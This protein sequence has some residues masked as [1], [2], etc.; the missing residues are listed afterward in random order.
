MKSKRRSGIRKYIANKPVKIG[1][2]L[3]VLDDRL[4]GYTDD[5]LVY[6]GKSIETYNHGLGYSLVMKLM[7]PLLNQEYH[8]FFD[9]VYTSVKILNGIL[10]LGAP[11]CG[12]SIE[13]S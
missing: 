6:T 11:A 1:L 8:L 3:W 13:S 2:K 4:T 9:N 7:E 10:C 12:T 5:F